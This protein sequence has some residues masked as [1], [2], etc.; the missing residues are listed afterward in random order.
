MEIQKCND[1]NKWVAW[2]H[3]PTHLTSNLVMLAHTTLN[4][5]DE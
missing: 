2:Y 4:I 3:V 1:A 5:D